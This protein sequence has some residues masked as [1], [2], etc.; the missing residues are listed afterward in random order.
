MSRTERERIEDMI[1]LCHTIRRFI[2]SSDY[3]SYATDQE[4][5]FAVTHALFLLGEAS[6]ALSEE[7][8]SAAPHIDWSAL[9]RL[10]DRLAH[11]Y[12]TVAN[13]VVWDTATIDVSDLLKSLEQIAGKH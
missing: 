2:G 10:R 13:R 6:K 9:A 7:T 4:K 5:Q 3:E 1:D 12:W 11:H 8:K